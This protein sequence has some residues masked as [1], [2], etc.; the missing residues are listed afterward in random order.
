MLALCCS[1]INILIL[2]HYYAIELEPSTGLIAISNTDSV[3]KGKCSDLDLFCD[4]DNLHNQEKN[5]TNIKLLEHDYTVKSLIQNS[6]Y[7]NWLKKNSFRS[8]ERTFF[9][10]E[11]L[12]Q[13]RA[14]KI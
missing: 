6:W 5:G 8:N 7:K 9:V 11:N 13:G 1:A 14:E 2:E 3:D 12:A 4:H 10:Y